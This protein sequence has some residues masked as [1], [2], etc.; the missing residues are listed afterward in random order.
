MKRFIS[1]LFIFFGVF[2]SLGF[3]DTQAQQVT[4]M[5]TAATQ[6]AFIKNE[7]QWNDSVLFKAELMSGAVFL[8]PNGFRFNYYAQQDVHRI[9]DLKVSDGSQLEEREEVRYHAYGVELE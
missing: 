8:T 6:L 3:S 5:A 4:T 7:G 9:H 1:S 2:L